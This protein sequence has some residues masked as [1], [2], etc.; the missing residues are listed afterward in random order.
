MLRHRSRYDRT[1]VLKRF[2]CP[3][4]YVLPGKCLFLLLL[5]E[6]CGFKLQIPCLQTLQQV[7]TNGVVSRYFCYTHK[8]LQTLFAQLSLLTEFSFR[9]KKGLIVA[10][11][12]IIYQSLNI[13]YS[14]YPLNTGRKLNV[15]K[16]FR[17]RPERLKNVLCTFHFRPVSMGQF[18]N[19]ISDQS[20]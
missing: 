3:I 14:Y 20:C 4:W 5:F 18:A 2:L 10:I 1:N 7:K 15:H 16:T 19:I 8:V 11:Y 12:T 13:S 9:V 17:R 6:F